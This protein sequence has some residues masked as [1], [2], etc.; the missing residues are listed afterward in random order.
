MTEPKKVPNPDKVRQTVERLRQSNRQLEEFTLALDEVIAV[1]E[2]D[3]R[4]QRQ[5]RFAGKYKLVEE[6][7]Q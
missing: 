7:S 4:R 2:T 3:L 1:V 5:E 6:L